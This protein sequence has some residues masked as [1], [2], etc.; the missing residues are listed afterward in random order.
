MLCLYSNS[1][2]MRSFLWNRTQN[3]LWDYKTL[4]CLFSP[5]WAKQWKK[6]AR[7]CAEESLNYLKCCHGCHF[8]LPFS[9]IGSHGHEDAPTQFLF[10]GG[11]DTL[12]MDWKHFCPILFAFWRTG[13]CRQEITSCRLE[14]PTCREW[15]VSRLLKCWGTV[16]ILSGWSLQGTPSV[17]SWRLHQLPWAGQSAH[18]LPFKVERWVSAASLWL[19]KVCLWLVIR[20]E[21]ENGV[22]LGPEVLLFSF[23]IPYSC[24]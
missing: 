19:F 2:L 16:G 1:Y 24:V 20:K 7:N 10:C 14:G 23:Q 4:F 8:F 12:W 13:G 9:H 6:P 15:P 3:N 18:Y 17:K 11:T 22:F 21:G 5:K